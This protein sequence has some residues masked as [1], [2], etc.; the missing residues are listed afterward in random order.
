[1]MFRKMNRGEFYKALVADFVAL[2]GDTDDVISNTANLSSL[3]FTRLRAE[4]GNRFK[5][6]ILII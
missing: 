2:V 3:L 5:N 4:Y 1:M 6:E